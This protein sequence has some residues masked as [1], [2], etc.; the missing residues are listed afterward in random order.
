MSAAEFLKFSPFIKYEKRSP[1]RYAANPP[2]GKL[3]CKYTLESFDGNNA[4]YFNTFSDSI[5][6]MVSAWVIAFLFGFD[7]SKPS[8]P[9]FNW[10]ILSISAFNLICSF[11]ELVT[12]V[13]ELKT[14][15]F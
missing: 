13:G 4:Q 12:S 1:L 3:P 6:T 9:A 7:A 15:N 10:L 11:S 5:D 2:L 8:Q 14:T